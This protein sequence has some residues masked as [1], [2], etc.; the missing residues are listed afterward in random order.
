MSIDKLATLMR[1]PANMLTYKGSKNKVQEGGNHEACEWEHIG[2]TYS[3]SSVGGQCLIIII[4]RHSIES[5][6]RIEV[7]V[8][9]EKGRG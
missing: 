7:G 3:Q 4:F 5:Q 1:A 2:L 8:G 6:S 9:G